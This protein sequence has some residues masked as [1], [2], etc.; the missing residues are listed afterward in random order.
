MYNILDLCS[1]FFPSF[2]SYKNLDMRALH[3]HTMK[4]LR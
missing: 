3:G 2:Q 4:T 1:P